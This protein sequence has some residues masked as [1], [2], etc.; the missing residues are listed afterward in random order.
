MTL[1]VTDLFDEILLAIAILVWIVNEVRLSLRSVGSDATVQDNGSRAL[2][3]FSIF[4]AFFLGFFLALRFSPFGI[5]DG[6][7]LVF[8][9]G[10]VL[11]LAGVI[12]R[13]YSVH[14]LGS[15]FSFTV[16]TRPNQK[17]VDSGPYRFVRHPSYSA[18]LLS[19]FGF[20]LALTNWLSFLGLIP[21]IVGYGYRIRVEETALVKALGEDYSSYMG[22]TKRLIP[23]IL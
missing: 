18:A 5:T 3:T 16:A 1:I 9:V 8:R 23:Y 14:V 17:V 22:R 12:L 13:I 15:Y 20:L 7:Q 6:T 11:I 19:T 21:L 10:V 2:L 4:L